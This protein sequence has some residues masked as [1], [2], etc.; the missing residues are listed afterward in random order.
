M[1]MLLPKELKERFECPV[2]VCTPGD[3]LAN[4]ERSV[5]ALVVSPQGHIPRVQSVLP[6]QRR[7]IAIT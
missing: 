1:R 6:P 4:P 7:P 5:G 3:L 2:D